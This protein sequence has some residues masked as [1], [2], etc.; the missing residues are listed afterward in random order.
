MAEISQGPCP[1]PPARRDQLCSSKDLHSLVLSYILLR[2]F[3]RVLATL[4]LTEVIGFHI[5]SGG[6]TCDH[7][8]SGDMQ[9]RRAKHS[10]RYDA[11]N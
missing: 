3:L 9:C 7:M 5:T 6:I 10:P 8:I 1:H 4:G 11:I 2:P